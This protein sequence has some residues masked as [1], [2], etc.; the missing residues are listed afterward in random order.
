MLLPLS[1]PIME[2]ISLRAGELEAS[3]GTVTKHPNL[4]VAYVAQHAFH[5]IEKHLDK[6]PNEYIQ[7]RYAGGEDREEQEK[8]SRQVRLARQGSLS[9]AASPG[10]R[11]FVVRA[12]GQ[13]SL[14]AAASLGQRE[15]VVDA[16]GH[17]V[18]GLEGLPLRLVKLARSIHSPVSLQQQ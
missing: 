6:T 14:S 5:H 8:V 12:C 17:L 11:K 16:C 7:W 1:K 9:A 13:G 15:C 10:Q 3:E 4:R 2:C 18:L